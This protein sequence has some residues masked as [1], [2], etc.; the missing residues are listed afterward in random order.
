M[1][2]FNCSPLKTTIFG[3]NNVPPT[4]MYFGSWG[5]QNLQSSTAYVSVNSVFLFESLNSPN[6]PDEVFCS[7]TPAT[8]QNLINDFNSNGS[9]Q[10]TV[11][12][13]NGVVPGNTT[14]Y[15][16]IANIIYFYVNPANAA[17]TIMLYWDPINFI[18]ATY[19][20]TGS[21]ASIQTAINAVDESDNV[22]VTT[23]ITAHSGGGQGSAVA[24]TTYYNNVTVCATDKDSVK[25]L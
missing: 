25:L 6:C 1:R 11:V 10:A 2:I 20:L 13:I 18:P 23:G 8:I 5:C 12:N 22:T 9:Y 21:P 19:L 16:E 7:D 24:L 14:Q 3:I 15:L 17:Q 4:T